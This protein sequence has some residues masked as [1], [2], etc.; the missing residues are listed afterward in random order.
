MLHNL[1]KAWNYD[2]R[3]LDNGTKSATEKNILNL[4]IKRAKY[5]MLGE[6]AMAFASEAEF[7]NAL[8]HMLTSSC[9]WEPEVLR[10]KT[11]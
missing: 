9:G 10:Y 6:N 7:E 2:G 1:E 5:S 4:W 8:I 3:Y 11:E